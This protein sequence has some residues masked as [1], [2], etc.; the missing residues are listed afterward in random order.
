VLLYL[1]DSPTLV[2]QTLGGIVSAQLLDQ[3]A[4]ITR[5]IPGELDGIDALKYDVVGTHRIRASKWRGT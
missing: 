2:A 1:A 3:V 5:D 4:S